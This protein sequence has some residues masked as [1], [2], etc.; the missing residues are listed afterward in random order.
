YLLLLDL[1][2]LLLLDFLALPALPLSLATRLLILTAIAATLALCLALLIAEA[3]LVVLTSSA[4]SATNIPLQ[5]IL[6]A[7]L[8]PLAALGPLLVLLCLLLL[9]LDFLLLLALTK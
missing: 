9:D 1:A 4:A 2:P 3:L 5:E 8:V 7:V 6:A